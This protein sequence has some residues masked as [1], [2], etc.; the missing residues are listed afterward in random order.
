MAQQTAFKRLAKPLALKLIS[1]VKLLNAKKLQQ[2]YSKINLCCGPIK[3]KDYINIDLNP[4]ADLVLDLEHQNLPFDSNS[5]DVLVCI[6][7]INYFSKSRG[8]TIVNETYR[9]LKPGGIARFAVQDLVVL[10]E[11]YLNRDE[12]FYF[13]KNADG[14]DR[15]HG[16]TFAEKL[17]SWFYGYETSEYK[18][19]KYMYDY[20]TLA[21]IFQHAGFSKVTQKQY[22]ESAIAEIEQID[23]RPEQMFFLEAIK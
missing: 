8:E 10:A 7:A 21:R 3:L 19:G 4:E 20:E 18:S 9:V 13:Q 23:N 16:E 11:K 2:Q 22:M 14:T 17:N 6:S 15:F 1:K 5:M 12:A